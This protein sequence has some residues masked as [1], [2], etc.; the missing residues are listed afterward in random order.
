[1]ASKREYLDRLQ[2][3]TQELHKRGAVCRESVPVHGVFCGKTV[4]R[5]EVEA[6]DLNGHPN[7]QRWYAW[8]HPDGSR[9]RNERFVTVAGMPPVTGPRSAV[10]AAV[11][12]EIRSR[13]KA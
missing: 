13:R 11:V 1:M 4:W 6:F 12:A 5:R 2:V 3:A 7:A 9:D 10:K 8:S